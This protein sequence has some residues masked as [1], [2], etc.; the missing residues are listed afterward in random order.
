M[1]FDI[2]RD[3]C[4]SLPGVTEEFPFGPDTIVWKVA[5]KM[6][7]LG[8]AEQFRSINLKCDP[9]RAAELRESIEQVQP[10]YHMNKT[11]WNTVVLDGLS[12]NFVQDLIR[13]S[14]DE[15]VRKLPKTTQ[16]ILK[17]KQ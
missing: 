7:C 12:W 5:G 13:H 9:E 1:W 16:T 4:V 11:M 14:Y 10:G 8:N 6:F 17:Q 15:V 2:V 3:Y